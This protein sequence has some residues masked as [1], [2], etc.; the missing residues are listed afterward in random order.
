MALDL[1]QLE[2]VAGGRRKLF[3]Y[4]AG[5]DTIATVTG[6]GYFNNAR[7]MLDQ[8]DVMIVIGNSGAT[9][10]TI[11]VSSTRA[12]HGSAGSGGAAGNVTTVSVEGVT[13]T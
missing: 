2:R 4:Y 1:T 5:A 8:Y 7:D 9:I 12:A 3:I 10:D 11:F 6:A 13:A